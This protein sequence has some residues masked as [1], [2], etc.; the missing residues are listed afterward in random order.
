MTVK[1]ATVKG[2]ISNTETRQSPPNNRDGLFFFLRPLLSKMMFDCIR[3][4]QRF[5][6]KA[7]RDVMPRGNPLRTNGVQAHTYHSGFRGGR[8]CFYLTLPNN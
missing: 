4:Y 6:V 5:P 1:R 8:V 3:A 2:K 7:K